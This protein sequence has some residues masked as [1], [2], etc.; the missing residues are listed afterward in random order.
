MAGFFNQTG[1][2]Q[3]NGEGLTLEQEEKLN[4]IDDIGA[5]LEA[6]K[7]LKIVNIVDGVLQ[8]TEDKNQFCIMEDFTE[9]LLPDTGKNHLEIQLKFNNISDDFSLMLPECKM[10]GEISFKAGK[11]YTLIF[12][13]VM[14]EWRLG[15]VAY[16]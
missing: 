10:Q 16:D 13:K 15:G 1:S 5:E 3:G 11:S 12:E 2:Q 4:K 9:I 6:L 8:L 14:Q 7:S